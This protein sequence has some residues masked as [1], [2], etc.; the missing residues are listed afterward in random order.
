MMAVDQVKLA[1]LLDREWPENR[2]IQNFGAGAELRGT[3]L[4]NGIHFVDLGYDLNRYFFRRQTA[5][6]GARGRFPAARH[7]TES[8]H[9]QRSR[10]VLQSGC[11][12]CN[13]LRMAKRAQPY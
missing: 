10:I 12:E 9:Q 2:V 8:D 3:L 6:A 1:P 11:R 7:V 4:E 5:R 13:R